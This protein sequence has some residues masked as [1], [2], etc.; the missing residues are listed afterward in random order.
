MAKEARNRRI[1]E[2]WLAGWTEREI[3]EEVSASA[4]DIHTV[5]S[6]MAGLP[7]LSKPDQSAATHASDFAVVVHRARESGD[8]NRFLQYWRNL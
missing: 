4:G 2:F 3:A 7:N 6:E 8:V 1:F 5:C